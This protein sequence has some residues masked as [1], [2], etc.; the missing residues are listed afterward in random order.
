M[1]LF[2]SRLDSALDGAAGRWFAIVCDISAG[3]CRIMQTPFDRGP[4]NPVA[5]DH[6]AHAKR[7]GVKFSIAAAT[8]G[9]CKPVCSAFQR[10]LC[11]GA[12]SLPRWLS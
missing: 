1:R 4:P 8:R 6:R 5:G 10:G 7:C 3:H 11:I 9:R 2:E 12:F